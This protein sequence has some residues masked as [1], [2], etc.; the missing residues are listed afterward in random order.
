MLRIEP[1]TTNIKNFKS[2]NKRKVRAQSPNGDKT[3]LAPTLIGLTTI[4]ASIAFLTKTSKK[5]Y[6][7]VLKK[8]GVLC[9]RMEGRVA[10]Y[11]LN[12]TLLRRAGQ[13]IQQLGEER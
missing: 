5:S 9:Y 13:K 3:M 10:F 11:W 12:K 2:Y 8:A 7:E 4:A 6:N 1:T